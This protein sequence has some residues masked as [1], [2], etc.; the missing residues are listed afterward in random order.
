MEYKRIFIIAEAGVNHNGNVDMAFKLVDVAKEAGA[1][2]IKF[3][4]FKTGKVAT[5]QS[6]IA[7]YQKRNMRKDISQYQMLKK[8]ELSYTDFK[9]IKIYCDKKEIIFLSTPDEEES[10]NFLTDVLNISY[11]KIGS[12][13]ITNLPFLLK[14]S[15]KNKPVILS[16]GMAD[17]GEIEKAIDCFK[18]LFKK[19]NKLFLMHCTTSYPA[20]Y[21]DANLNA[22]LTIKN[23]FNLPAGY[24]DHT[25]G[26]E[27]S[28]GAVA[29]GAK[30]IEKH[31]T[32]DKKLPG[33]DHKASLNPQELRNLVKSIRR[34]E[35][36]LGNGIK[37]PCRDET[38]I[39]RSVR[40]SLVASRD[41]RKDDVLKKE[42]IE[43]KKPGDG[44]SPEF[45][46]LLTGKKLTKDI[47][48]D[49]VFTWEH[50]FTL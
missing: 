23:A 30:I 42:D 46:D 24:S 31:F 38:E 22:M 27:V 19:N 11:I 6:K 4:T 35:T 41:L 49:E 25:P 26:V 37:K 1:D 5:R 39:M 2:A 20:R 12:S 28:L 47:V 7:G 16:T 9:R 33:P 13:D 29:M 36:A 44:I 32:L 50:F 14:V 48:Q 34:L 18:S 43:F 8:L 40:K 3:Q 15:M 45:Y 10:L 17:L 21:C